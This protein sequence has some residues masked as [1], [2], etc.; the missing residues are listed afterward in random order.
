VTTSR[1]EWK[2]FWARLV[3]AAIQKRSRTTRNPRVEVMLNL[4]LLKAR[5][6]QEAIQKAKYWGR[7]EAGDDDGSL[8]LRG[9]PA[10]RVFLGIQ[11]I[12][13][14]HDGVEDGAEVLWDH[15]ECTLTKAKEM[16]RPKSRLQA[17]LHHDGIA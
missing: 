6:A 1:R 2:W 3:V 5:S 14:L 16:V 17:G 4:I 13:L 7:A 12:G 10:R 9:K 11:N 15:R 8:T